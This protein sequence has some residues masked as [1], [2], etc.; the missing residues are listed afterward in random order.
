MSTLAEAEKEVNNSCTTGIALAIVATV[1]FSAGLYARISM[2]ANA[3][4]EQVSPNAAQ[5]KARAEKSLNILFAGYVLFTYAI[6]SS[7][8][9]VTIPFGIIP[10]LAGVGSSAIPVGWAVPDAF[11]IKTTNCLSTS[12]CQTTTIANTYMSSG[13]AIVLIAVVLFT[14]PAFIFA[15]NAVLRVMRVIKFEVL[16]GVVGNCL[17]SITTIQGLGWFSS[18][19]HIVGVIILNNGYTSYSTA[20]TGGATI[21]KKT[22]DG[23]GLTISGLVALILGNILFSYAATLLGNLPGVGRSYKNLCYVERNV[24]ATPDATAD[25]DKVVNNPGPVVVALGK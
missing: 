23:N 12:G 3:G 25:T 22:K 1:L 6:A 16:P 24:T 8:A 14:F 17:P 5:W 20:Q 7:I 10:L 18:I 19:V 2:Y 11:N 4:G 15:G 21:E 13:G 9:G